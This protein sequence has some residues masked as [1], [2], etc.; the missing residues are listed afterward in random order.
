MN[1]ILANGCQDL[2]YIYINNKLVGG[3]PL[4]TCGAMVDMQRSYLVFLCDGTSTIF[5]NSFL[6]YHGLKC[7]GDMDIWLIK[8]WH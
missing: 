2:L 3:T 7:Y 1:I 8:T 6:L 5:Y 4:K